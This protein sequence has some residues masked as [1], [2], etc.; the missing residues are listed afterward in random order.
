LPVFNGDT[1]LLI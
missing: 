1:D